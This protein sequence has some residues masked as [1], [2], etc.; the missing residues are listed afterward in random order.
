MALVIK[1]RVKETTITTGTGTLTLAGAL[2][3]FEA[4]SEIGDGN[5]TY[6]ACTDGVDFESLLPLLHGTSSKHYSEIY[7][8]YKN[9]QRMITKG[10]WKLLR[11]P[12]S[13]TE[14]LFNLKKDPNEMKDLAGNPEYASKM[15]EMRAA[16]S[17]LSAKLDDPLTKN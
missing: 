11:Y 15:K 17:K 5:N 8:A 10:D 14:R 13:G 4:F 7:G 12:S 16:L 9:R 1:D 2:S 6:Y 3:G